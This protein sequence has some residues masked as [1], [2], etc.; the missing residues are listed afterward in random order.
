MGAN[1]PA[2]R[3][4]G[5]AT[6][7]TDRATPDPNTMP[8]DDLARMIKGELTEEPVVHEPEPE[9]DPE[10]EATEPEPEPEAE[11]V[12]E[13]SPEQIRYR[14]ERERMQAQYENLSEHASRLAG[15]VGHLEQL[16]KKSGREPSEFTP[17]D[18][19]KVS[20]VEEKLRDLE[21]KINSEAVNRAIL[22]EISIQTNRPEIQR[23][24]LADEMK[25]VHTKYAESFQQLLATDDPKQ[26]RLAA[27][28]LALNV[29]NDAIG[30]RLQKASQTAS[31]TKATSES[32]T[33]SK[34]IAASVSGSGGGRTAIK[35]KPVDPNTM[36]I[37]DLKKLIDRLGSGE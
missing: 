10:P 36:P 8:L 2:E 1:D 31:T 6:E 30:L 15:K 16:L 12:A 13:E 35:P 3:P 17:E 33:L 28:E 24:N 4:E 7:P 25:E 23:L 22:E 5:E 26:A 19:E 29:L 14:L 20:R 9:P 32:R 37:G 21:R 11:P 27:K 18:D 34:K